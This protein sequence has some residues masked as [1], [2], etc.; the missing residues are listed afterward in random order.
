MNY[1]AQSQKPNPAAIA[2]AL[3]IPAAFGALL[4]AG[5]A[6][7]VVIEDE[8]ETPPMINYTAPTPIPPPPPK[9]EAKPEQKT[10]Q[11]SST[12]T[13]PEAPF[14]F[15]NTPVTPSTP[16]PPVPLPPGTLPGAGNGLGTGTGTPATPAPT[17][18]PP[19]FDPVMA[20]PRGNPGDWITTS[21]YRSVWIRRELTGSASFTLQVSATGRVTGCTITASTGH[22]ALD[23]AT[24]SL[25]ERRARF[26]P[27]R[28]NRGN[29]VAGT[30]RNSITWRLPE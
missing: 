2:G 21:D 20:K 15:D 28:D 26:D 4:I 13:A 3:G 22:A 12:I 30:Y 6:V 11:S 9:P 10:E 16:L 27:A 25:I 19:M 5:L 24:C 7:K 1:V 8:I 23:Q 29:P 18:S 17:L 14:D